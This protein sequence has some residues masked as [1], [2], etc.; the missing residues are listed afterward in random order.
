MHLEGLARCGAEGAVAQAVG[1]LIEGQVEGHR[2][3]A[4]GTAQPQH[5]LPILVFTLAAVIAIVLLI[6]AVE[7]ED[8]NRGLTEILQLIRQLT[9]QR[10]MQVTAAGLE[11]L[12]LGWGGL[13][14]RLWPTRCVQGCGRLGWPVG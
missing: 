6:T 14:R 4:A 10:F 13:R 3:A 9:P 11:L 5:H 8:L 7:L 1:Q 12:E 2:D